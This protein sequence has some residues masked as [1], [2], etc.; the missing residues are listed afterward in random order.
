MDSHVHKNMV[1]LL[2]RLQT[3]SE[4]IVFVHK[5]LQLC[6]HVEHVLVDIA[7]GDAQD[8]ALHLS[9]SID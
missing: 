5:L 8:I 7:Q 9:A 3:P 2:R 4:Q 6:G 1:H